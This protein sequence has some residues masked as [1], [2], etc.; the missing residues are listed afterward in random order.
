MSGA[1]TDVNNYR[2]ISV[3]S[4]FSRMLDRISPDQLFEFLQANNTLTDSQAAFRKLYSTMTSLIASTGCWYKNIDCSRISLT[5]FL[6]IK[7]DFDGVDHTM[8]IQKLQNYRLEDRKGECFEFY[9]SN[10]QQ[11]CS[12]NGVK[13]KPRKVPC[14]VPQGSC[15]GSLLFIIYLSDFEK[16]LQSSHSNIYAAT[17]LTQSQLSRRL[18]V[19]D[20]ICYHRAPTQHKKTGASRDTYV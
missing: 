16:C 15:L 8:R 9:L 17:Q 18:R 4:V 11:F 12:L 10:R 20:R 7:R 5:I 6:D 14:G 13:S 2:P 3:I 1:R 19:H